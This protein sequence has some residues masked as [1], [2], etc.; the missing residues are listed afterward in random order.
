MRSRLTLPKINY[1]PSFPTGFMPNVGIV[2]C[3][4]VARGS[5]LRAYAKFGIKVAGVFDIRP[6]ATRGV[7]DDF[8]VSR[9]LRHPGRV[10][11]GRQHSG[12]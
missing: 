1:Q 10:A 2:G 5:H 12:G 3:G 4:A 9:G 8:S 11:R 6:E 7:S